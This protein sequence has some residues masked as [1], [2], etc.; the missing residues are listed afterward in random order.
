M[1]GHADL[2]VSAVGVAGLV[3]GGVINW[4]MRHQSEYRPVTEDWLWHWVLPFVV[5]TTL[6]AAG[7]FVRGAPEAALFAIGGANALA[8]FIG[9]HNAWDTVT[10]VAVERQRQHM[11]AEANDADKPPPSR[12]RNHQ[13]RGT[14]GPRS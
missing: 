6:T 5:Y 12:M 8:L 7:T 14:A 13:R 1:P 2:F 10:Y 9:I 11:Q 4:R 3:Y